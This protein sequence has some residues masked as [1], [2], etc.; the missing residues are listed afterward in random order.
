[1]PYGEHLVYDSADFEVNLRFAD[2]ASTPIVA[3]PALPESNG[4][5]TRYRLNA[6]R[7]FALS[8]SREFLVSESAVGSVAVRSYYFAGHEDAGV[9]MMSVGT[10]VV[11]LFE[12]DLRAVSVS[13]P[14]RGGIGIQR[15]AG[16][17]W[18]VFP[19]Q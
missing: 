8:M 19:E 13:R 12:S 7:T 16:I 10:Q 2:P 9:K 11:G 18:A 3:A 1:M 17:R 4:E 15:R 14:Q 5:W 6:A